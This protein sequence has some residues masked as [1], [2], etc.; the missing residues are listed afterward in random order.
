HGEVLFDCIANPSAAG[1]GLQEL[2]EKKAWRPYPGGAPANVAC[3][4]SKL[5]VK[6]GFVG[7]VG[8]DNDGEELA[9][10]MEG[11]GVNT[12][13]VQRVSGVAT[14]TV[15][16]TRTRQGERSFAGFGGGVLSDCFADCCHSVATFRS[17]VRSRLKPGTWLVQGTLGLAYEGSY[18][19]HVLMAEWQDKGACRF[20]DINWRP[21]FW[22]CLP[23]E[24]VTG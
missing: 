13:L 8:E 5:G 11:C 6:V 7:A 15:M 9:R 16:V 17:D 1:W 3:A 18:D 19:S 22:D 10:L 21:V 12:D 2:V 20:L 14:R 23:G 24:Q 4:L